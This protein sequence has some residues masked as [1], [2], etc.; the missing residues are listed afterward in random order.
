MDEGRMSIFFRR[1]SIMV[2]ALIAP[3]LMVTWATMQFLSALETANTFKKPHPDPS[4]RATEE[5]AMLSAKAT[6]D[7]TNNPHPCAP[8]VASRAFKGR[9]PA[10]SFGVVCN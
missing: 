8:R 5:T 10:W 4:N 2:L 1:L 7:R 9:L 6:L 3:E